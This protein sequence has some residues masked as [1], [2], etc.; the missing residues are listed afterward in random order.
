MC[1]AIVFREFS[2]SQTLRKQKRTTCHEAIRGQLTFRDPFDGR[3]LRTKRFRS[4]ALPCVQNPGYDPLCPSDRIRPLWLFHWELRRV[5]YS[6]YFQPRDSKLKPPLL[7][8]ASSPQT[9]SI[10][11]SLLAPKS[12]NLCIYSILW[13]PW[14][15]IQKYNRSE[16]PDCSL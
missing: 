11:L 15:G 1:M 8:L 12:N 3:H 2:R 6:R 4:L 7:I 13:T 5:A 10:V 9:A 16:F 14:D